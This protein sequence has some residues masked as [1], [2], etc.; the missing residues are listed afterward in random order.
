MSGSHFFAFFARMKYINRWSLMRNVFYET[1]SQHSTEVASIAHILA[2]I[3]NKRFGKSYNAERA[4]VL[5]LYHDMP[6]IL[7]GDMPTPVKYFNSEI[8]NAFKSVEREAAARLTDSLPGYLRDEFKTIF[9]ESRDDAEEWRL[10]K[11]A[12]KIAALIKC[13]E[14]Q[15]AGNT[16]FDKAKQ[17]VENT[18]KEMECPEAEVFIEEFLPSF[19]LTLDQL[20]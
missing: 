20:K 14:E 13:I 4:A 5:G 17:S 16:E 15:K 6:E 2:L 11:A 1:L 19:S 10:V 18:L 3:V 8:K 9:S 12:D 7:T